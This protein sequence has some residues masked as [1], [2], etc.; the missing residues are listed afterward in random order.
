MRRREFIAGLGSA[1]A[2]PVVARAQQPT[3][4][5]IG[6]LDM[7]GPGP[8]SPAAIEA[9]RRGLADGGFVEG[10][11]LFI[12]YRWAGGN[13]R[14]VPD[15]AADLVGRQ[16]AVIVAVNALAPALRAKAATSTIPIVFF[17]NGD[18]VEDHLVASLNR[19][20]GNVTGITS[21]AGDSSGLDGKR[22]QLL[23]QLV[24]QPR[25]VAFL[26]GDSS[27]SFYEQFTTSMLAAGRALGLEIMIV[28][29]SSD[30]D[31]EAALAKMVEGRADAMIV[32]L[33]VLPN[34]DK[35]VP[36]AA[37]HKL[38]A[39][40]PRRD[41]VRIGGLM[42]YDADNPDLLRRLGSAYV[43]RILKGAKP[44]DLPV[45]Q[46]AKFGLSINLKTAKALGLTIPETLL[47][48]ADEVIQ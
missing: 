47:A 5:V 42:S 29:C 35:L 23:S 16:V 33:F 46:P 24:P 10:A 19:P 21:R 9:F 39:I 22:L 7:F 30:R 37:L 20:G 25:K 32:G 6:F 41:F 17:Y 40:Y 18:P 28:E 4:P 44:A 14:R 2:W 45:E 8:K 1:A 48:T 31:Y 13:F 26:S 15:L 3:M 36:L 34:L 11:N 43:A 38:P 12:E 27:F